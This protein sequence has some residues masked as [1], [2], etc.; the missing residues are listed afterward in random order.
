M[1]TS[2]NLADCTPKNFQF[3]YFHSRGN[4][5]H[6]CGQS[7]DKP[8]TDFRELTILRKGGYSEK[9]L[10]ERAYRHRCSI[11]RYAIR[12]ASLDVCKSGVR[13]N[14]RHPAESAKDIRN[15]GGAVYGCINAPA[16][17]MIV[18]EGVP[19]QQKSALVP[20]HTVCGN[21]F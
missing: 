13:T 16:Q 1:A 21:V 15:A 11:L 20:A 3:V 18:R 7:T 2:V 14:S 17:F 12:I 8:Q 4:D 19:P 5:N 6:V 10:T 9:P